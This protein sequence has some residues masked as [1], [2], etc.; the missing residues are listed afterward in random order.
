MRKGRQWKLPP[1]F[2][3]LVRVSGPD[4]ESNRI[5]LLFSICEWAPDQ[6]RGYGFD[7]SA[8]VWDFFFSSSS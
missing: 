5:G 4:P 1:F 2:Y 7:Y 6:V 8:A 3:F